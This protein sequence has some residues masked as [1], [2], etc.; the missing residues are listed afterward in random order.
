MRIVSLLPAATDLVAELGLLGDLV[1]RTHEC[2][3]PPGIEDV[4]VVTGSGL[5]TTMSSREISQAVGGAHAG[6]ALYALDAAKLAE[7]RPD[8]VL[9]QDLCDLCAVSYRHVS[10]TLRL[11]D[12]GPRVLSLEPRTLPEVLDCVRQVGDVLGVPEVARAKHE[13][14][15]ARLATLQER[16][17]R[18]PRPRVAAIEWLDPLW[19]AGHWVPE[20]ITAAG[21]EPLL[22]RPGEH[23]KAI[24]W[25]ELTAA[26]PDVLLLLPCGLPPDRTEAELGLLT[27]RPGWSDLPA[28]R[29]GRVWILDGPSYFNRPGPRVVRGAEILAHVLHGIG[30]VEPD[31]ARRTSISGGVRNV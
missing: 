21:G 23:T 16:T 27:G 24:S 26:R 4:P 5:D 20:Q 7:L 2:D 31:Q 17:R 29:G 22:A 13:E 9:T 19:P 14:L 6:S 3:W 30:T 11:M 8:V 15:R 10:G 25:A 12:A 18:L 28:V 1:G